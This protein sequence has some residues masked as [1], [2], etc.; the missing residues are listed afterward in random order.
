MHVVVLNLGTILFVDAINRHLPEPFSSSEQLEHW[1]T[2]SNALFREVVSNGRLLVGPGDPA[3][4]G[5]PAQT[6][7]PRPQQQ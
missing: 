2:A 6:A 4:R 3:V 5:S 7:Q 1:N